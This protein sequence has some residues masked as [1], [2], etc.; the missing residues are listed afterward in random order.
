VIVG[1]P[2]QYFVVGSDSAVGELDPVGT[3]RGPVA[4]IENRVFW[5]KKS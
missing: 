1:K 3:D 5:L 4:Y 2:Q